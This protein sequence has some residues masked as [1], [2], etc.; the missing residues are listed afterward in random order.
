MKVLHFYKDALPASMGGVEVVLD[1]I[2]RATAALGV[3]NT[4]LTCTAQPSAAPITMDGYKVV[5]VRENLRLASTAFSWE[6]IAAYRRLAQEADIIHLHFPNPFADIL[7]LISGANKPLIISY[8]SDIVRQRIL[9]QFYKP[10]MHR[11]FSTADVITVA[12]PNLQKSSAALQKYAD[13]VQVIPYGLAEGGLATPDKAAIEK[14]QPQLPPRFFLFT[15][16]MRYYKGLHFLLEAM[17]GAPH[18]LVLAGA[19]AE[20]HNLQRQ[21]QEQGLEQGLDNVR[22]LGFVSEADK[23]A[24][25]NLCYGFVFPSHL[26]S[27]AFGMSLVEA[28][29]CSKPMISCEIGTGTSYVNQHDYTGLVVPPASPADLRAAMDRLVE[30]PEQTAL[31]GKQARKHYETNFTPERQAQTYLSIYENLLNK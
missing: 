28:A 14:W 12:S 21:A 19:G 27:E 30:Y 25:L 22:F 29:I 15:G 23:A 10:I 26:P 18:Q 3:E 11:F 5:Q 13:K 31:Y 17:R 7:H 9:L 6:A 8:H 1:N 16:V 24:L 20:A 4:V 2:C